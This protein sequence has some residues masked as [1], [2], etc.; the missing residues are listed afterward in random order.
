MKKEMN[1]NRII[2]QLLIVM[3]VVLTL[4]CDSSK[5]K[6]TPID[7]FIGEWVLEGRT[8]FN[9][10][11]VSIQQDDNGKLS[12]KVIKLN[13]NK[14]VNMFVEKGDSWVSEI[15]RASNFEFKLTEKKIG[16]TLFALYGQTT[17]KEFDVQFIDDNT[18]GL[19]K[20]SSDPTE[21]TIIYKRVDRNK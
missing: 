16:S 11:E 7:G 14:Y 18:I 20:G 3:T 6:E 9:G 12:G 15:R 5:L 13:D 1:Y 2:R 10:I 8:I 19:G 4:S 21:S 17:S